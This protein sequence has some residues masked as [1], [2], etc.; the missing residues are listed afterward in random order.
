MVLATRPFLEWH[1]RKALL[2]KKNVRIRSRTSVE[3]YLTDESKQR[4]LGVVIKDFW[5]RNRPLQADLVVDASGRGSRTPRWLEQNGYSKPDR[6]EFG[7]DITYTSRLF[8][9]GKNFRNNWDALLIYPLPPDQKRSGLVSR[10]EKGRFIVTLN[11]YFKEEAPADPEGFLEYAGGLASPEI[12][13]FLKDARPASGFSVHRVPSA[14]RNFYE[15]LA[16]F[17]EGLVVLGDAVCALNPV[18]GQGMTTAALAARELGREVA[19][20]VANRP[21][22]LSN[23]GRR[24]FARLP[25]VYDAPWFL[26]T[27]EDCRYE[28][29]T[30]PRRFGLGFLNWYKARLIELTSVDDRINEELWKV[31]HL[32]SGI[33]NVLK[34]SV[35]LPVLVHGI[36]SFFVPIEK[37]ARTTGIPEP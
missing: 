24:F 5:G 2:K 21:E 33:G 36:K 3:E 13:D 30:G 12:Y 32:K 1:V 37:R 29:T 18:F 22:P 25:G 35:A 31:V 20:S 19:A 6:E 17:P 14:Y 11:G 4:I 10:V 27:T 15:R 8:K 34:P 7:I 16:R 26:T 28:E 9:P 23:L